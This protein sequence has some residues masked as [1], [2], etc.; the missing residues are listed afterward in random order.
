MVKVLQKAS[1]IRG[2]IE[3]ETRKLVASHK[4][5]TLIE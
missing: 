4:G 3:K 5:K 1:R 2:A